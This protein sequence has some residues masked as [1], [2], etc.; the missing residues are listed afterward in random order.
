[1]R[2]RDFITLLGGGAAAWPLAAHAQRL[3][4]PL[5]GY[6]S[7]AALH[8]DDPEVIA[9]RKG[10]SEAGYIEGQNVA[11]EYRSAERQYDRLPSLAA[12]LVRREVAVIFV[13]GIPAARAAKDATGTIPIVFAFGEDP[14]KEGLVARLNRPGGNITGFSHFTNQLI[15]KRLAMLCEIAPKA[16]VLGFLVDTANPVSD[17]D[18]E[19]A[20]SAAAALGRKLEV[21]AVGVGDVETAFATMAERKIGALA[22]GPFPYFVD[23]SEQIIA[24][25][26]HYGIAAIYD[27]HLFTAAGGLASY[28]ADRVDSA[29]QAGV[30]VG[31]IL[32]G[33]KPG[34]LPVQQSTKIEFVINLKAARTIGLDIPPTVV[35]LADEVIE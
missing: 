31:R 22:V 25:A 15:G 26:T 14:V 12:D 13:A 35:A 6:L 23:V 29:R 9:L 8:A 30:Y 5:V 27:Q 21:V 17:P 18:A 19:T 20:R 4:I 7:G 24:L 10:L 34:E 2:R 3:P 28:G 32:K 11:I 1:M 16:T 33:E